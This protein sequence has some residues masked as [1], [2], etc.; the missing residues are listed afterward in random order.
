V[1]L[2]APSLMAGRLRAIAEAVAS[3]EVI[4]TGSA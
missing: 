3:G 1:L 4:E 2:N